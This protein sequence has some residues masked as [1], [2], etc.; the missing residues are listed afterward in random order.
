MAL[1]YDVSPISPLTPHPSAP[2][3]LH[4]WHPPLTFHPSTPPAMLYAAQARLAEANTLYTRAAKLREAQLGEA[5]PETIA[6][7]HNLAELA[8]AAG[9]ERRAV[10]LQQDILRRLEGAEKR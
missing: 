6:C 7:R 4:L 3:R 8:R 5:H 2:P 1:P 9:D 10:S